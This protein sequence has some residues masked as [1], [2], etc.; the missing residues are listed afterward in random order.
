MTKHI[1]LDR[2]ICTKTLVVDDPKE[3]KIAGIFKQ[4]ITHQLTNKVNRCN[5]SIVVRNT[6]E[7]IEA[8]LGNTYTTIQIKIPNENPQKTIMTAHYLTKVREVIAKNFSPYTLIPTGRRGILPGGKMEPIEF[9]PVN[10]SLIVVHQPIVTARN[11]QK[12]KTQKSCYKKVTL[13]SIHL[14]WEYTPISTE[15]EEK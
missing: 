1:Q 6:K 7:V 3:E 12:D 15:I 11:V 9:E 2:Y 5:P 13:L 14:Q 8:N 4:A 10:V